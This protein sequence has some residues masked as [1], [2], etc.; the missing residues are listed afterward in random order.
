MV[1]GLVQSAAAG[2]KV[3]Q[4]G[5]ISRSALSY[6]TPGQWFTLG[7]VAF[8]VVL[9]W[10][11]LSTA[12]MT[13]V[14][15][16]GL[17]VSIIFIGVARA[18]FSNVKLWRTGVYLHRIDD[19]VKSDE[20]ATEQH[21]QYFRNHLKGSAEVLDT[22][23]MS[24]LIGNLATVGHLNVTDNDARMIKS[25]LGFRVSKMR[26][27][28]GYLAGVLVMLGLLGTFWGLLATIDAVGQAMGGMANISDADPAGMS[29]F[30]GQIAAPLEGMGLAFSS[31]LFGLSGSLLIG[32]YNFLCGGVHNLFIESVS[33]W[34]DERIPSAPKDAKKAAQN[35]K[36]A[37]SDELKAWLASY[38]QSSI[39]TNHQVA[40][41]LDAVADVTRATLATERL[42]RE[43]HNKQS[44]LNGELL[45]IRRAYARGLS[46][47][48]KEVNDRAF[49]LAAR[50]KRSVSAE[51]GTLNASGV[52][53]APN[54]TV[55]IDGDKDLHEVL[56]ELQALLNRDDVLSDLKTDAQGL[57]LGGSVNP[58]GRPSP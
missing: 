35:P 20:Q 11:Q 2:N 18:V 17:I 26:E 56:H 19:L 34:I 32:F 47:I 21:V 49:D 45:E 1:V 37:S 41:L 10:E 54:K 46:V 9:S 22:K 7:S 43:T 33:R 51:L 3:K 53:Q 4:P 36:V 50:L 6:L 29:A 31:S 12:F 57:P 15:L 42:A 55:Q 40:K 28:T 23:Q 52:E 25:K 44:E 5:S 39:A 8:I 16:N 58:D 30:I 27:N 13:N 24:D 14:P 48:R 38:V